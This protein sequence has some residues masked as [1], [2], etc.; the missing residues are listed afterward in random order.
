M[1]K[2]FYQ[3]MSV[4]VAFILMV[5]ST[6]NAGALSIVGAS[7]PQSQVLAPL[8][9]PGAEGFGANTIGGRGGV[10]YEVTNL[11]DTGTGSLRA[12]V[13][14][15]GARTCVFRT[16]G[17]IVL[18]SALRI[19]NPYITIAGQTAPGGGITLKK[20]SGGD[21]FLT[22]THDVII[23]YI[24]SRPGPGGENHA[25]QIAKN[26][27][28][29]Y[30][31]IIDHNSLSW[32][33]DSNIETWYRVRDAS[34]QWSLI[35]EALNN[36]THSK[37]AHSKGL[38]IGGYQGS[39][40]GGKGSENISVLNNLMAHN[41]ERNPLM[42]LCGIAQV[43]NNTTYNPQ[44]TFSHQQLNCIAGES[45][46]NWINNYHK[47]GPSST[48]NSDLKI[49][50]ADD[51]TWS[52][53]KAYLQGNIGPGRPNDS[54]SE[55]SWVTVK[56]GAPAGVVVT[57]P[58]PAPAVYSTNAMQAYNSVVADGGVGNSRGLNCDGS[59][60]NRRDSIDARVINEVKTGTGKIIDDPS[61]VGGWI[62]PAAGVP[63]VDSD[64][65]G[66]PNVWEQIYGFNPNIADGSGDKDGDGYTNVE[67]YFNGTDTQATVFPVVTGITSISNSATSVNFTVAFSANVT[68]VDINDFSLTTT[69]GVSG[70]A[71]SGVSGS[72]SSYTVA[73]NT[74]SGSGTIRLN[75]IDNNSIL[76]AASNPLGGAAV[77][78]GNF[79][80][81]EIY[82][83]D[84]LGGDKT[85]VFRPGNGLLYLK[86]SNTSGF[87][88]VA[89]N[90]GAAGDYP[91]AGDWDG[92]GTDTIG[93]YRSGVFYLRN[94][95]TV[96]FADLVF[97]FGAPG[98]QPVAG[99]WN[100]DGI[101]T[102][103]VYRNG[104]FLLRNSNSAGTVDTSFSLGNPG[105][106]GIA[107][108]WNG[109]T[110]DSTGVFRPGNGVI[111][112]KNANTSGFADIALNYGLSG[113]MPVTGDW[114]NDGIDTIGVYRNSQFMLR[115][116]NTIG[117]AD[118]VFALGISGDIP[119]AGNW[120][121]I[122]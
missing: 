16:G 71:V 83:I 6:N 40:S 85:G 70:A 39:E 120:N 104:L 103:G 84:S 53:G 74:G 37:G 7:M 65:D 27:T 60:V 98:D 35:S 17:L 119:I 67:E 61:Q 68:G 29:L 50:P 113:D 4:F 20:A 76:D 102:I 109:D 64:H 15:S 116:S 30:N 45:Y 78:D 24:T 80:T 44:W 82:T 10:I 56:S 38:M 97:T 11:N 112:L 32:G 31:I 62:I 108:D 13:E 79:T 12:C 26:G 90:Y 63:C 111:F 19:V 54:L 2:K 118:I 14:A 87:A 72:G 28:E 42:Q 91:V 66:M 114:N 73:V 3:L 95:N 46:I 25:N 23:R 93:V 100:G 8:A 33:V 86:N 115:N 18:Q 96:G 55:S 88:N 34:I 58:A 5:A 49:I 47:K 94:S 22:Q 101:D 52:S 105:D 1:N 48:S 122:P 77:G 117:F 81:G 59:W 92:N 69:G 43:I 110:L 121:G 106:I 107:G 41:A 99:D 21:V 89:I 9:F 57:S 51:G 36:S 75:V